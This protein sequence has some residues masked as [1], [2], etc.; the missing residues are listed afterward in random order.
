M[1]LFPDE[2]AIS[3][4]ITSWDGYSNTLPKDDRQQFKKMLEDCYRY[5][6]A[7]NAKSEPFADDALFMAL[8]FS[9]HKMIDVLLKRIAELEKGRP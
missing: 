6:Q 8:L 5:S 2:D 7:I 3:R 1:S 4:L 9:Q